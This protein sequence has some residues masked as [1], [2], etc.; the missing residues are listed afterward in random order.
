MGL[1]HKQVCEYTR[2][3]VCVC[4]CYEIKGYTQVEKVGQV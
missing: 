3:D 2:K 4:V 1:I